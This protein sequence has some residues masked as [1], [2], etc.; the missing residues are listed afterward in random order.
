LGFR[1]RALVHKTRLNFTSLER[2]TKF[3]KATIYV[4]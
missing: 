2:Q 3:N 4:M 1:T